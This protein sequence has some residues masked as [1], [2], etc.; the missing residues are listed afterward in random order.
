MHK[1]LQKCATEQH[2]NKRNKHKEEKV[3]KKG[4]Q[5]VVE[6]VKLTKKNFEFC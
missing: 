2:G 3:E 4:G 5:V 1:S 6:A